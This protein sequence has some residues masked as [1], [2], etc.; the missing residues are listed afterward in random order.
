MFQGNNV[1]VPEPLGLSAATGQWGEGLDNVYRSQ[2]FYEP[3][4]QDLQLKMMQ[5]SMF[6]MARE[7][8]KVQQLLYP[9]TAGLQED[10]AG[11][12]IK[13]MQ[14]P[15]SDNVL[16][17]YISDVNSAI[18][19]NVGSP[20]GARTM[21]REMMNLR[22]Q[23]RDK[24]RNMALSLADRQGIVE[25][26]QPSSLG[27]MNDYQPSKA[28]SYIAQTYAPYAQSVTSRRNAMDAASAHKYGTNMGFGS[29]LFGSMMG[30]LGS[31]GK[32][33]GGGVSS[34]AQSWEA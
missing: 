24:F 32:S 25:P 6:P 31:M 19:T 21:G 30:G 3:L 20:I 4:M 5:K 7:Y 11:Q 2:M 34:K 18:G 13:G 23:G 26:Q 14:D 1:G 29:S 8:Q 9:K 10:L 27:Y 22:E 33:S 17:Q 12:A 28:L 15:V 16:A